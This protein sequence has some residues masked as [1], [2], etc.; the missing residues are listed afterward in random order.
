M[1]FTE[2]LFIIEEKEIDLKDF[3]N[4]KILHIKKTTIW[5]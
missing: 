3:K 2:E 4:I 1:K 5:K